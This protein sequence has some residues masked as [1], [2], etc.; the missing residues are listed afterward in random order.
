M[1]VLGCYFDFDGVVLVDP[2]AVDLSHSM[3][4]GGVGVEVRSSGAGA[5][6]SG[7][8]LVGNQFVV[9]NAATGP[10]TWRAVWLNETAGAFAGPCNSTSIA[11]NAFPEAS[12]GP[13]VGKSFA[14]VQTSAMRSL[15][16]TNATHWVID[17][18]G[19]LLFG[20]IDH[21]HF[22]FELEEGFAIAAVRPRGAAGSADALRVTVETQ[23]PVSGTIYVTATQAL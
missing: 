15:R 6:C 13:Y 17:F 7:L 16:Q 5:H 20:R 18:S 8:T 2:V 11:A 12:Y 3:F 21:V 4:L 9:G 23:V 10:S 22:S 1:R 19:V 14:P